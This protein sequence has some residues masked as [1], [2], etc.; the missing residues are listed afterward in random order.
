[1]NSY[2]RHRAITKRSLKLVNDD[3]GVKHYTYILFL[4][5]FLIPLYVL[6]LIYDHCENDKG[7]DTL[8]EELDLEILFKSK[9]KHKMIAKNQ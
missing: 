4:S 2:L 3:L 6:A 8:L 5:P 9:C 7:A 1:M